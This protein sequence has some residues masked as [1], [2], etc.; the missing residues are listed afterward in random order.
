MA[1]QCVDFKFQDDLLAPLMAYLDSCGNASIPRTSAC[2]MATCSTFRDDGR[3]KELLNKGQVKQIISKMCDLLPIMFKSDASKDSFEF[4]LSSRQ[5]N[6][7]YNCQRITGMNK[8]FNS[9]FWKCFLNGSDPEEMF[10]LNWPGIKTYDSFTV[11]GKGQ[12]VQV[13]K[14]GNG[15][16]I[17]NQGEPVNEDLELFIRYVL[18]L[19]CAQGGGAFIQALKKK[20]ESHKCTKDTPEKQAYRLVKKTLKEQIKK[21]KDNMLL[22]EMYK[23]L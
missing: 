10:P 13:T 16:E 15:Y 18:A 11:T 8:A 14:K 4:V 12:T 19:S 9:S 21:N 7:K 3:L 23:R 2:L 6:M 22:R 17:K 20:I 5:A 1:E